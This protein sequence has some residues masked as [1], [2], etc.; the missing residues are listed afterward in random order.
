MVLAFFIVLQQLGAAPEV[1]TTAF[2][3]VFSAVAP[4]L[5]LTFGCANRELAGEVTRQ[6]YE[7]LKAE[8]EA[9]ERNAGERWTWEKGTTGPAGYEPWGGAWRYSFSQALRGLLG[10]A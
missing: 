8:R 5:A 4:V 3:T 1:A 7:R 10:A 2:V 6:G 9:I